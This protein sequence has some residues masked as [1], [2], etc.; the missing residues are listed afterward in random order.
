MNTVLSYLS[1]ESKNV[2]RLK[3]RGEQLPEAENEGKR[4]RKRK[5]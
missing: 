3:N 5:Y 2:D 1:I 4:G